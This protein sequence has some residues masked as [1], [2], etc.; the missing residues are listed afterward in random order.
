MS[1]DW[2][3]RTCPECGVAFATEMMRVGVHAMAICAAGHYVTASNPT[4]PHINIVINMPS[5]DF[6]RE[7]F[8]DYGDG[9]D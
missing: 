2:I 8:G 6:L 4:A 5:R 7:F 9:D 1:D 3:P